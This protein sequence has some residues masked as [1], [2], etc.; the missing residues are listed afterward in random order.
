MV[1]EKTGRKQTTILES[2]PFDHLLSEAAEGVMKDIFGGS[3]YSA[4]LYY[5]EKNCFLK[6]E[7][8]LKE[9]IRL[10]EGL[11]RIFGKGALLIERSIAEELYSRLG[12]EF[13]TVQG[14]SFADC[15][16][17]AKKDMVN[18]FLRIGITEERS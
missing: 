17:Y 2:A 18:S 12:L 10:E 11:E 4:V 13:H 14:F 5:L 3:T 6:R 16:N 15:L 8:I 1:K 7:D 9:P